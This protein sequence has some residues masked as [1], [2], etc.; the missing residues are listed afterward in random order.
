MDSSPYQLGLVIILAILVVEFDYLLAFL[1]F[2]LSL[3]V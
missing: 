1:L 3:L 2:S